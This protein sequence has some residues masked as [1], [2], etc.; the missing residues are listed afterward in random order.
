MFAFLP[1][2]FYPTAKESY[3]NISKIIPLPCLKP[4]VAS[5]C[6]WNEILIL[7]NPYN[8]LAFS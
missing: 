3:L 6:L 7:P 8:D 1:P 5:N 2:T 4:L